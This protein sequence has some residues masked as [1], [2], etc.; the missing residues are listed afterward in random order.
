MRAAFYDRTGPASEVLQIGEVP[1]PSAGPGEV[2]VRVQWSGVNPSDVKS[3]RGRRTTNPAAAARIIPHSDGSGVIEQ[4]GDGVP[5]SRLGERVWTWNAGWRR[6]SGTAAEYVVLPA[7]QAVR[8]PDGTGLEAG[9]CLG[10]PAL[11]ACHAVGVDDGV[12]GKR[13]LIP[14]GAGAVGHYAIQ[15]ARHGGAAQVLAT[16]SSPEK[17]AIAM[18]AG[19]DVVINYKTEDVAARVLEATAGHGAD[20]IVEVDTSAN[21]GIDLQALADD[22]IIIV[23]G[24][25][26]D[27][28]PVPFFPALLKNARMRFF[29]VY[30]LTSAARARAHATLARL[31]ED[32]A[33]VHN[34]GARLKLGQ[35]VEAHEW[36]EQGRV[37]GN[38]VVEIA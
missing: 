26:S 21:I 28:I 27:E 15:F 10:I 22:G 11:T 30:T 3:R 29:A 12:A 17:A 8:L 34:I 14:G 33:L 20:R 35:I 13:V 24:S 38:V 18:A 1:T 31:L 36:V 4:V 2:R 6:T 25:G 9:A 16:V 7:A 5:R 19:A 23:Y 37:I 32:G